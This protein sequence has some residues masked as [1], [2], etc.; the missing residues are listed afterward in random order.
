M[1][2]SELIEHAKRI[3]NA[4]GASTAIKS[5]AEA[6][7]L[8]RT[9]AGPTSSFLETL[10]LLRPTSASG[11]AHLGHHT[12]AVLDGFI[13]YVEAGLHEGVSPERRA[14]LDV[15]SDFLEQAHDLLETKG[16][17]PAAPAVLIGATLEEFLRTWVEAESLDLEGK[18]P[19]LDAYMQALRAGGFIVKQDVKDITSWAGIRNHAAHGEWD[20]VGSKERVA[21]MLDGVNLFM[22]KYGEKQFP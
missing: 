1:E 9:Y 16:V 4:I 20:E 5:H 13:D 15:V 19:G 18:K 8:L 6:A 7:A 10:N 17:H 21:V 14:Q 2:T 11:L 12:R 3:R 22:R